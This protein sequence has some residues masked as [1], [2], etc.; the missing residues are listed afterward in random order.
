MYAAELNALALD[1]RIGF[2][3]EYRYGGQIK[4]RAVNGWLY[5]I[6]HDHTE[7]VLGVKAKKAT[8]PSNTNYY[9]IAFNTEIG[10]IDGE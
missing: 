7:V 6:A 1:K 2:I 9:K 5:S 3:Q 8:I 10:F 4:E